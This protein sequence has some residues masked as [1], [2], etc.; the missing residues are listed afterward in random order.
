MTMQEAIMEAFTVIRN[1]QG[2]CG[3]A[4]VLAEAFRRYPT[5][6]P[7]GA[8]TRGLTYAFDCGRTRVLAKCG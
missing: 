6:F 4:E 1:L 8:R 7:D 3:K 2:R 5:L